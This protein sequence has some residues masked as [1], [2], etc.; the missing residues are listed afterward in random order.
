VVNDGVRYHTREVV[1]GDSDRFPS[2]TKYGALHAD[3][4]NVPRDDRGVLGLP[5]ILTEST[6][7]AAT[8]AALLI[9]LVSARWCHRH[10]GERLREGRIW[11]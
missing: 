5:A 10:T 11:K 6:T 4:F 7:A 2:S 8:C 3:G 9:P 1:G